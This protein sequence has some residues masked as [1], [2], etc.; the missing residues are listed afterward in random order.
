M[1]PRPRQIKFQQGVAALEFLIVAPLLMLV[2]L[3][4]S[5]LG[6]A[7]HQ[8]HTM[9]R[10]ARDGA[11]HVASNALIG[12][13]GVIY[14]GDSVIQET[15]NLVVYGNPVGAGA[16]ILPG[17]SIGDVTVSSPDPEHVSVSARYGYTPLVGV[18]PAFYGGQSPSLSFEMQST[19]R[20]RAL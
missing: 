8:Y 20:M 6:W 10:A 12:S 18:I 16:P 14:L 17:W 7:F 3:A 1:K 11:R 4:V 19:V 9:T 5:E 2:V 15:R 13:V